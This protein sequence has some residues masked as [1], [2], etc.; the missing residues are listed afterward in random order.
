MGAQ[1]PSDRRQPP[2]ILLVDD[3]RTN[4]IALKLGL[5]PGGYEIVLAT[6]GEAA[7]QVCKSGSID[8]VVLDVIMPGMDGIE[9]A[10]HLRADEA[11]RSIPI[12]FLT[13]LPAEISRRFPGC[14][15]HDVAVEAKPFHPDQL[16]ATVRRLL[17]LRGRL[18]SPGAI[19]ND[20]AG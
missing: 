1:M 11:T 20:G 3:R 10:E 14:P 7:L 13:G 8:L 15:S 18:S 5:E 19:V 9:V 4:L 16:L 12:I 6:D 17:L 2:T